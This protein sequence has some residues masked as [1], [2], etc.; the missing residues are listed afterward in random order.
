MAKSRE[1]P[2]LEQRVLRFIRGHCL[3]PAGERVVVA[4]SGGPDSVCLLHVLADLREELDIKLTV[5]HL[6]HRLRGAESAADAQYVADL[7]RRLNIASTIEQRDV[8]AYQSQARLSL[9]EAAREVRYQ[10]LAEVAR[11][12]G[13]G[14]VAVGHTLD[15]HIETI[16]MHL[17]RGA[18]IKGLVG[19]EP[20]VR[21]QLAGRE[22]TVVRPLLEISRQETNEY[23][24]QHRLSARVD[25]TNLSLSAL[26]NRIRLQLLPR[27]RS[28][29]PRVS[30]ALLRTARIAAD[31]LAFLDEEARGRWGDIERRGSTVVLDRQ[32]FAA[33][34][35]ALQRH[36]LR[37]AIEQ[38]VGSLKDIEARHI[39][40]IMAALGKPAGKRLSLPEG[41]Q[42]LVDYDRFIIGRDIASLSPFPVLEGEYPLAIPGETRLPG[43]RVE[44]SLMAASEMPPADTE[45]PHPLTDSSFAAYLDFDE[46]GDTLTLRR[47]Q[48]GDR[49]QPLGMGQPKKL[50]QFMIDARIPQ[51]WRQRVAIVSSPT[52]V[53]WVVGWRI[54]DRVKVTGSTSRVL[55][56]KL[57]R[58]HGAR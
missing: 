53:L 36:L 14:R 52:Q 22:V 13:A 49:F 48:A 45:K 12:V 32:R 27:L 3:L 39:E 51:G 9:E 35:S 40:E 29:N 50:G 5:A 11:S 10:F 43:W 1:K 31:D 19:L 41:L 21:R 7:A 24:R 17:V 58:G 34:P 23:C 42:F 20:L 56:L 25:A 30:E 6:D 18:G 37:V 16:L 44:A 47:R 4:V 28:Y 15:D 2:G 26:R 46:A 57:V 38:V 55:C 8:K 54:D 33:L